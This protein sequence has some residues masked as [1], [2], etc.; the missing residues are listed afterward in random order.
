MR[1]KIGVVLGLML[2]MTAARAD[3]FVS[4]ARNGSLNTAQVNAR[5]RQVFGASVPS[6]KRGFDLYKIRYRSRDEKGRNVV[7]SGLV[8]LPQGGAPKGSLDY[9]HGTLHDRRLSPSRY[10]GQNTAPE[11]AEAALIFASGNY[12]VA[13]P[14]YLGLGDHVGA[15][16]FPLGKVNAQSAI[17]I[18]APARRLAQ[19]KNVAVAP[20]LFVTGYS[21]GGAVAMWTIRVLELIKSF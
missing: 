21:E 11:T 4:A 9:N 12:A 14:D 15:H 20:R 7:L 8:V 2:M 6:A 5:L 3:N 1:R 13:V 19:Q 17:D 16:P 18:I 10:N